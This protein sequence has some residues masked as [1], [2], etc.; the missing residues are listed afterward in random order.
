MDHKD[1]EAMD[2]ISV[3]KSIENDYGMNSNNWPENDVR[4]RNL[5]EWYLKHPEERKINLPETDILR[6]Q[7]FLDEQMSKKRIC[8]IFEITLGS[9]THDIEIG[10]LNDTKWKKGRKQNNEL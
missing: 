10:L 6:I 3:V 7:K 5:R 8:E 2:V 1:I 4:L 9:L